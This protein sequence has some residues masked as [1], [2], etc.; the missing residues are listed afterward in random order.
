M[1][2]TEEH[3]CNGWRSP[4]RIHDVT[5]AEPPLR[6]LCI[7]ELPRGGGGGPRPGVVGGVRRAGG[8]GAPRLPPRPPLLPPGLGGTP[9]GGGGGGPPPEDIRPARTFSVRDADSPST[10]RMEWAGEG[11]AIPGIPSERSGDA[12]LRT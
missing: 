9:G 6:W 4:L 8:G 5:G 10:D 11:G 7:G 1:G 3:Y 2:V 12:K